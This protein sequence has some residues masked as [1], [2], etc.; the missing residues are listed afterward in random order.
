MLATETR[1][2]A[3]ADVVRDP[4][5]FARGVLGHDVWELP[6]R[7]MRAI[8]ARPSARVAVKSC[9]G[10]GKTFTA[11]EITLWWLIRWKPDEVYNKTVVITTAPTWSQ[12]KKLLWGEIHLAVQNAKL[13][14]P[15]PN[16]TE[17][18]IPTTGDPLGKTRYAYGLSTNDS[19]NFQGQHGKV[20]I[21]LDEAPG[22]EPAIWDAIEGIR[23]A[24]DVRLLA[25]GNP[26]IASG[27]FYEAF[28]TN[29]DTW[30]TF[31]ISAFDTPNFRG[32]NLESLLAL[33]DDEAATYVTRPY[34][35]TPGFV[36]EKYRE[37]GPAHPMW[38]SRVLGEFPDQ[39]EDA[40]ISLAWIEA[41]KNREPIDNRTPTLR[42]GLDVA[43]P[44]EDETVLAVRDGPSILGLHAWP[45]TDPRGQVVAALRS[46][47]ERVK[48]V[49]VDSAGIGYYMA[50]HL[51]DAGFSVDEVNVGET[52]R[53]P[54][55]FR[56]LKAELYWG[57]RQRLQDG[58]ARG[59]VDERTNAQLAGIRYKHT[60][61]GQVEIESKE[62]A[63]KRGVKSPDRAEAVMLAFAQPGGRIE[64]L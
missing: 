26:V 51:R 43:G 58:D 48:R 25:I 28:T 23:A 60:S 11:A 52:P 54:E 2:R 36:R 21:V 44:G 53:D 7:I 32:L 35:I 20:L 55:K 57:L 64:M 34:L 62:E 8:A 61:R 30:D 31:T 47:G 16:E 56:N 50:Q 42:A 38:Q 63:R 6:E 17:I 41:A 46:Y 12:V 14:I 33:S 1:E 27:P 29:R 3:L 5:R 15:T 40:L 13:E 39:A 49:K 18:R 24:G 37:W 10:S 59:F 4:A 22:V 45:D 19:V 9:H